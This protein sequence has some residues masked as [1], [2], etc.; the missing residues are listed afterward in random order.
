MKK[1]TL[2]ILPATRFYLCNIPEEKKDKDRKQ[3]S[4]GMGVGM[5][6]DIQE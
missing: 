1:A 2:R 6:A 4:G 5:G 3:S